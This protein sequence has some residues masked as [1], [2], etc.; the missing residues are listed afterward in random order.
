MVAFFQGVASVEMEIHIY[1]PSERNYESLFFQVVYS[2]KQAPAD[3]VNTCYP[4]DY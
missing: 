1:F 3:S 4:F 2:F